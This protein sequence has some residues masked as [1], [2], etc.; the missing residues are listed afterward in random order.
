VIDIHHHVLPDIDDGPK[1]WDEA[2]EMCRAALSEG[3]DTI[4]ATPHVLRGR[5]RTYSPLELQMRI[6]ELRRR[7]GDAPRLLLGS[8]Y[9][10]SHD[11]VELLAAGDAIVPLAG[12]RYVLIELAANSVPPM[13]E[14]PLYRMQL[15]GW[16]PIL[17]HPERNLVF[18][19]HPELLASYI[20]HGAKTQLTLSSLT[21]DFGA[22]AK[23]AA[24]D[25]VRRNFVH[26]VATDAH[27]MTKRAP[28]VG[29]GAA[30][31]H[32]LAGEAVARALMVENPRCVVE[33]RPLAYDPEPPFEENR[34]FLTRLRSFF[35]R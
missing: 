7:V 20:G 12:S 14:Q 3:I 11:A 25:M 29:P 16:T 35:Q 31:L 13:F 24:H 28:R 2:V 19:R 33:K 9:F 15:D 34:G 26:F 32:E 23:R 30:V 6:D 18:Q 17:A 22:E 27:N 21:G 10:F 8:E 1:E 5:W 4:V